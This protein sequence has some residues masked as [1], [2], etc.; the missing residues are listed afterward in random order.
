VRRVVGAVTGAVLHKQALLALR[1]AAKLF[2]GD[3][4]E[5]ARAVMDERGETG[6]LRPWH[7][8]EAYVETIFCAVLLL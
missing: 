7:V 4:I 1:T 2:A 5:E 3:V 8:R 6:A